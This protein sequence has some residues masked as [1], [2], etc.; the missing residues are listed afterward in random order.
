MAE[1]EMALP[2]VALDTISAIYLL[3]I[4]IGIQH[5]N[6]EKTAQTKTYIFCVWVCFISLVFDS[7][8]FLLYGRIKNDFVLTLIYYVPDILVDFLNIGFAFYIVALVGEQKLKHAKLYLRVSLFLYISE[9]VFTTVGTLIREGFFFENGSM[10]T[11]PLANYAFTI[12]AASLILF[13]AFMAV[14]IKVLGIRNVLTLALYIVMPVITGALWFLGVKWISSYIGY[15]MALMIVFVMIQFKIIS[16]TS[17]QAEIYNAL[18]VRDVLTGLRNRRGYD[19]CLASIPPEASVFV[20]FCDINSLKAVNDRLGHDAGDELIKKTADILR[21][22]FADN[23]I[24]RI[25]G[26]EFVCILQ[27][28]EKMDVPSMVEDLNRYMSDNDRIA[29]IGYETGEGKNVLDLVKAAEKK[30]YSEKEKYYME[31]GKDRRT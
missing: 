18:S 31:T 30:M 21:K 28:P 20:V 17:L 5:I 13:V 19:E 11:G 24:F 9:I 6:G 4:L 1:F 8:F 12:S 22:L 2:I 7:L 23:E 3:I 15:A 10:F 29:S 25:S 27:D 16:K 14:N 26:D